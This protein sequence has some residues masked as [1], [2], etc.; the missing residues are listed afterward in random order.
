MMSPAIKIQQTRRKIESIW[1]KNGAE[2][3]AAINGTLPR[4]FSASTPD[5]V[6]NEIPVFCFHSVEPDLFEQQLR[7][8]A[9]NGYRTVNSDTLTNAIRGKTSDTARS[10]ALTFDDATGS[11]WAVAFPLLKKY[12][13]SAI[14]FVIPGLVPDVDH[15]Y[16]TLEDVWQGRASY[17]DVANRENIQ[18]LCTWPELLA[19]HRSG[20][21]DMQA[22]SLTHARINISPTVVD[23]IHPDFDPY[24]FNNIAIPVPINDSVEQPERALNLGQPIYE[25]ASRLSGRLRFMEDA[26]VSAAMI[27]Y[28]KKEGGANFF[29]RPQWRNELYQQYHLLSAQKTPQTEYET[30]EQAQTAIGLELA[31]SKEILEQ[32]FEKPINDVC[33]PWFQ[34]SAFTDMIAVQCGYR[35]VYYGL[36]SSEDI[37]A[38]KNL[39]K[40]P[41]ISE[42]YL[43]CLPGKG[44]SRLLKVWGKKI[45][46]FAKS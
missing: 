45:A 43:F 29:S 37:S 33:Y 20:L 18:P 6:E 36:K 38:T 8:L 9:D 15:A 39:I 26:Q 2:F 40:I 12:G 24:F 22:H 5:E 13:F 42:E 44:R 27:D 17:E 23:F 34:G 46:S 16:P 3:Q 31:R 7:Y 28:V 4:F 21:V 14:L 32:R 19:M 25:S 30:T 41:R 11:F 1:T 35:A 10:V